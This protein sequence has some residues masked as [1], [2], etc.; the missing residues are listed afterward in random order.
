MIL[1]IQFIQIIVH[2]RADFNG[3]NNNYK[4]SASAQI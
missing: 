1:V 2:V 4:I 3:L